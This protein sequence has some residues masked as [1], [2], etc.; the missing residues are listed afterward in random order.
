M[1]WKGGFGDFVFSDIRMIYF[2]KVNRRFFVF[3]VLGGVGRFVFWVFF[4]LRFSFFDG[5]YR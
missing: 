2:L 1:F 5:F 4:C 3:L